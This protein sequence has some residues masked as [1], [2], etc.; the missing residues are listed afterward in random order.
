VLVSFPFSNLAGAKVRPAVV[1]HAAHPS[2]DNIVVPLTSR[3]QA[4]L[5]GEFVLNDWVSSG[6]NV[7][8][9]VKRGLYTLEDQLVVKR[10]GCFSTRDAQQLQ[11]SLRSWLAI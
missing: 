6:L 5:P 3:L 8:T 10:L 4:L 2:R 1:V 11:N 9:A 7:P